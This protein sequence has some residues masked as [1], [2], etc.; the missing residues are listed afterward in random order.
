MNL[1]R[2]FL[3]S[4][5]FSPRSPTN[6]SV[7]KNSECVAYENFCDRRLPRTRFHS[8]WKV[9]IFFLSTSNCHSANL[10]GNSKLRTESKSLFCFAHKQGDQMSLSKNRPKCGPN[11]YLHKTNTLSKQL[12][13]KVIPKPSARFVIFENLSK[14]SNRPLGEIWSPCVTSSARCQKLCYWLSRETYVCS[15]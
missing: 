11:Y 1:G 15:F 9:W 12:R 4:F 14:E 10:K 3:K 5:V 2:K 7:W 13:G 8:D 6:C